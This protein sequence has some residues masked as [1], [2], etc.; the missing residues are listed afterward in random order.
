[1]A[2]QAVIKVI[3]G[4]P[5]RML[6]MS[7]TNDGPY[8]SSVEVANTPVVQTFNAKLRDAF[9]TYPGANWTT[10]ARASGDIIQVDGN[11]VGASNL[12]IS[13]DPLTANS[14]TSIESIGRFTMPV[15]L[16][17]GAHMS[18]RTL[19]QE[20]SVELVSTETP[21]ALFADL[22]IASIQQTTTTLTVSTT[23]PHGLHVGDRIGIYG[24]VDS[25]FNYPAL[26]VATTPTATSF[27]AT[28]GPGGTIASVTAGPFNSGYVFG[29]SAMGGSPN[30]TSMLFE[31][32][33]VT[34]ATFYTKAEGGDPAPIGGT[35]PSAFV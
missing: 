35:P 6:D 21:L 8:A 34:N 14:S 2:T 28:A 12:V 9:Q 13:V 32:A 11:A 30:G 10:V 19:G 33:T 1:M 15:D 18:Q 27:T 5:Y 23:L 31:S 20:F 22:T 24:C 16:A 3:D 7:G 26:V 4:V 17:I 29:R 25:R